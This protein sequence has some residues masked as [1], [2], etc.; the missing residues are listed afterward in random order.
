MLIA[1]IIIKANV[2]MGSS[3]SED[4]E[5]KLYDRSLCSECWNNCTYCEDDEC[6]FHYD[7]I[8]NNAIR[9][10]HYECFTNAF[11]ADR[12]SDD[13]VY[14]AI[15][16][17]NDVKYLIF[18][19]ENYKY[20][21]W[22]SIICYLAVYNHNLNFLKYALENGCPFN[23]HSTNIALKKKYT[24]CYELLTTYIGNKIEKQGDEDDKEYDY[25][26]SHPYPVNY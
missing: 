25:H 6:P 14:V 3:D 26:I 13:I 10:D 7:S 19:H 17:C 12:W 9:N 2:E 4:E 22:S 15:S 24:Y 11:F 8:C 16:N 5:S 21:E 20:F 1:L 23:E 18:L